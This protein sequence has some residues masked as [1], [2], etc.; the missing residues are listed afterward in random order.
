MDAALKG[1]SKGRSPSWGFE[2]G[3]APSRGVQGGGAPLSIKKV[4]QRTRFAHLHILQATAAG[5]TSKIFL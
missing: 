4:L 1:G 3:E 2:L 5:A